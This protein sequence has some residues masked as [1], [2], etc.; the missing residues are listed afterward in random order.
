M[1]N[2]LEL[3]NI[4]KSFTTEKKIK[5]LKGLSRKFKLG[6]IYAI[7]GPSG[8]GKST[9]LNL[10]SLID[11]PTAGSIKFDNIEIN[12]NEKKKMIYLELK[13]LVLFTSKIISFLILRHLKMFI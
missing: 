1:N 3:N 2:F 10:I 9:L 5:V 13:K 8:S 4:Q 11:R 12:F 7:M 6:K